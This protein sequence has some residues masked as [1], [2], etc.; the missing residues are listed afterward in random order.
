MNKKTLAKKPTARKSRPAITRA[1]ALRLFRLIND[2]RL[3]FNVRREIGETADAIAENSVLNNSWENKD[4]FTALLLDAWGKS[5]YRRSS[6]SFL[7]LV[8]DK[9]KHGESLETFIRDSEAK[10]AIA[11]R[12]HFERRAQTVI[13][14]PKIDKDT[15]EAV[16]RAMESEP[17]ERFVDT[18]ISAEHGRKIRPTGEPKDRL[19][20]EWR[21]WKLR[22][23]ERGFSGDDSEAYN[24]AWKEFKALLMGLIGDGDFWHVSHALSILPQLIIARQSIDRLS[25][26]ERR[27]R[28][29]MKARKG[30]AQ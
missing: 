5:K 23:L 19:S 28:A 30:G 24:A 14:N 7:R 10:E 20:D 27:S 4:L 29:G 21:Y 22:Q 17:M 25:Q 12:K 26:S 8:L 18:V 15:R 9:A 11:R 16:R 1:E 6:E 3:P 2:E 13:S